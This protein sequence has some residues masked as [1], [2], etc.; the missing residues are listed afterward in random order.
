[1]WIKSEAPPNH[2]VLQLQDTTA[3]GRRPENR[4]DDMLCK[5]RDKPYAS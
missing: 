2:G 4:R 1:M 5:S 3:V